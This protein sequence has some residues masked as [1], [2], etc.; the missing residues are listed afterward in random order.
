M[1]KVSH[2]SVLNENYAPTRVTSAWKST[3]RRQSPRPRVAKGAVIIGGSQAGVMPMQAPSGWHII[4]HC[5]LELL[6]LNQTP[7][8]LLAP[9]DRVRFVIAGFSG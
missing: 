4:G 6:N 3:A 9:G 2:G 8:A 7:P 1:G 5:A